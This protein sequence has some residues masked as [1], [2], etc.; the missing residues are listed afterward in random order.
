MCAHT[1]VRIFDATNPM[2]TSNRDIDPLSDPDPATG[3]MKQYYQTQNDYE[4]TFIGEDFDGTDSGVW[5][6]VGT[7]ALTT[8]I[9]AVWAGMTVSAHN[10]QLRKDIESTAG[11]GSPQPTVQARP[12]LNLGQRTGV[13]GFALDF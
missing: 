3:R 9:G 10:E 8:V 4:R 5:I 2:A 7:Y 6:M 13:V 11:R 1:E 12:I